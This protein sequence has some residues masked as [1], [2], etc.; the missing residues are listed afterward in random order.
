MLGQHCSIQDFSS[1]Q[2]V[3]LEPIS[4]NWLAACS[5][6]VLE[7]LIVTQLVKKFSYLLWNLK[8]LYHIHKGLPLDSIL[9]Q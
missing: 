2:Y 1:W 3:I 5:R 8:V 6:F 4:Y 9:S 7:K